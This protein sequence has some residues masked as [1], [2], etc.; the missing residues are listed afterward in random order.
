[1][2]DEYVL[3]KIATIVPENSFLTV[4]P[5]SPQIL[6]ENYPLPQGTPFIAALAGR[7]VYYEEGW[8][9]NGNE[10]KFKL[11]KDELIKLQIAL[12]QCSPSTISNILQKIG[13]PYVVTIGDYPC[14]VPTFKVINKITTKNG[15]ISFYKF[16]YF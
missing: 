16:G 7:Q 5:P 11:R 3:K 14:L 12:Q 8:L 9:P 6:A 1:L 13:S 2:E 4:I 15:A 10:E